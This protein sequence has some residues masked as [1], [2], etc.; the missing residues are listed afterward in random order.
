MLLASRPVCVFQV[1]LL[2]YSYSNAF[3]CS[4]PS[5]RSCL[6]FDG[7]SRKDKEQLYSTCDV[8]SNSF[9]NGSYLILLLIFSSIHLAGVGKWIEVTSP[10]SDGLQWLLLIWRRLSLDCSRNNCSCFKNNVK[11]VSW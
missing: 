7:S 9:L 4:Y 3:S 2:L 10:F 6:V 11:C 5:A 8:S 1:F